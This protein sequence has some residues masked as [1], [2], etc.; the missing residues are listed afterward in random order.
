[1]AI[2]MEEVTGVAVIGAAAIGA[3]ATGE[4]D[5][6]NGRINPAAE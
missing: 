3:A 6:I 4:G 1:M 5:G 2:I